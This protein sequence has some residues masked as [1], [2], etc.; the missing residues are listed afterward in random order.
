MHPCTRLR[1]SRSGWKQKALDR[2]ALAR[3]LRKRLSRAQ[4]RSEA[5]QTELEERVRRLEVENAILRSNAAISPTGISVTRDPWINHRTLCV[6][7]VIQG[8]VAFRAIPRILRVFQRQNDA[9]S[10]RP[11][12]FTS[13]IHWTLRAGIAIL[14]GVSRIKE[15]WIAVIDCSI[16]IGTR[17]ALVVLRVPLAALSR[18]HAAIGLQECECIGLKVANRWNGDTVKDALTEIFNQ[19]GRPSAI[20]MDGGTDLKKGVRL[21]REQENA[22]RIWVLE[23]VG[24]TAANGLKSEFAESKAFTTFL[25]ILRKG[26][27]RIRQ[28]TLAALRPPQVRTKGRFQGITKVA[29]WALM[30]LE[31]MGGQG[32]AEKNSE[33]SRLRRAFSGLAQLRPFLRRFCGTCEVIERFLKLIKNNGINQAVYSEAKSILGELPERS[34]TRQKMEAWLTRH[35]RIQCRL[36]IGQMGLLV[37]SDIIES[38]FGKFKEIVQ[39]HPCA[40]LNRLI[41]VIP[42]LCGHHTAEEIDR[43][44]RS[45]SHPEMLATIADKIPPT[46]RQLRRK[47]LNPA[48]RK[49]P[50]P[51]NPQRCKAG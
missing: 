1:N 50:K 5:R 15:P 2:G 30:I 47:L 4:R 23:D 36:G 49:V 33:L 43:S 12:H 24:H 51:G 44:I 38:L 26:A 37:S 46:L 27:A 48:W 34:F 8:V 19:A 13:V 35:L 10:V 20:L 21:Y 28:T 14:Q 3:G 9:I 42:L 11:P 18:K 39:R 17:K 25:D 32:R 16:D 41:Y 45:C 31:L 7:L 22:K 6:L 40:E 29:E